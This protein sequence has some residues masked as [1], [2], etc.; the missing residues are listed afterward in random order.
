MVAESSRD[1][2]GA[3]GYTVQRKH[4]VKGSG[5]FKQAPQGWQGARRNKPK[6]MVMLDV[7]ICR[8]TGRC[9]NE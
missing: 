1:R 7:V 3:T 5:T 8:V 2:K 6:R 9:G 4:S